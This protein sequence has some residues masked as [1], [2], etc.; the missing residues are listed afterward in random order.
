[1]TQKENSSIFRKLLPEEVVE[2]TGIRATDGIVGVRPAKA[3]AFSGG[4]TRRGKSQSPVAWMAGRREND[5][6]KPIDTATV[7]G[8]R[9]VAGP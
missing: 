7:R 8:G 4:Q 3:G 9:R 6:L 1:M 2:L 5:D